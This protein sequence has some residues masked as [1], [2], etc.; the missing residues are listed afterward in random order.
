MEKNRLLFELFYR[1]IK[2]IHSFTEDKQSNSAKIRQPNINKVKADEFGQVNFNV[3]QPV[4]VLYRKSDNR[5]KTVQLSSRWTIF[6]TV[7]ENI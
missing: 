5:L 1:I 7:S 4:E 2:S 3:H 6:K